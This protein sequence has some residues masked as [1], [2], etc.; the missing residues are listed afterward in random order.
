MTTPTRTALAHLCDTA[1]SGINT[2]GSA[3]SCVLTA[4]VNGSGLDP[5]VVQVALGPHATQ[6]LA[7]ATKA[8]GLEVG[9]LID[10]ADPANP[11][12]A[13]VVVPAVGVGPLAGYSFMVPQPTATPGGAPL[14]MIG[15][16]PVVSAVHVHG[17]YVVMVGSDT[18]FDDAWIGLADNALLAV[19]ALAGRASEQAAHDCLT[20][21]PGAVPQHVAPTVVTWPNDMSLPVPDAP[22]LSEAFVSAAGYAARLLPAAIHDALVDFGDHGD[23][24]GALLLRDVPFGEVPPTPTSP[25][26]SAA[27]S[28]ASEFAL[29]VVARRLGQPI[30]Y[31]PEHGGRLVQNILPTPQGSCRQVSTSSAVTLAWHTEAAFHR[32]LP[33]YLLLACLR[34]DVAHAAATTFVSVDQLLPLLSLRARALL[35]EA[36]YQFCIDESY[37]GIHSSRRSEPRPILYGDPNAPS[38][39]YDELEVSA[40]DPDAQAALDELQD[41]V[42][43]C[44]TSVVLEPG[45]LLVL[46]NTR[47]SHGRTPFAPRYDGTDRWLQRTFVVPDLSALGTDLADRIVTTRFLT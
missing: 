36:R 39:C 9:A 42:T 25:T 7:D 20:R 35:S 11:V 19:Y 18:I 31:E 23:P 8:P 26:S 5:A 2:S 37:T 44:H 46:D 29:L 6:W 4:N 45:D 1:G 15:E 10:I 34:G 30:G 27:Q 33:H 38:L 13:A 24:S 41:A 14:V 22:E 3:G 40:C 47:T 32:Y 16:T 17:R 28:P 12:A 21:K 43:A